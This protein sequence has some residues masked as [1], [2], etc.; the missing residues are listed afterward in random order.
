RKHPGLTLVVPHL[1]ADEF[2]EYEA[3]LDRHA[4]LFLDTTMVL[5]GYFPAGPDVA[6][7]ARRCDRL[8]YGTDFP[9]IPYAW[10]REIKAI[11]AAGLAPAALR[12]IA[13]ENARR[14]FTP[15]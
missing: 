3:M 13:G 1:G 5:A 4:R 15:A 12:K 14:V 2:R 8:L 7:L 6:L 11:A 9:N 10:D